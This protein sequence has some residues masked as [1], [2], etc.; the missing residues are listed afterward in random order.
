LRSLG[1]VATWWVV[2]F[3]VA[4]APVGVALA[5]GSSVLVAIVLEV[6]LV[7]RATCRV[8]LLGTFVPSLGIAADNL[9]DG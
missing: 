8:G 9:S 3:G 6:G 7:V 1:L 5:G 2:A 4:V